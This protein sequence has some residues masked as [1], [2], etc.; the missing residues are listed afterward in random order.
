MSRWHVGQRPVAP[1][2]TGKGPFRC[3]VNML[4]LTNVDNIQSTLA[5]RNALQ[6]PLALLM[7]TRRSTL[8]LQ[9]PLGPA[10]PRAEAG[11]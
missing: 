3:G 8:C 9:D 4:E 7:L 11:E 5:F 2:S 6:L 1:L 10:Q